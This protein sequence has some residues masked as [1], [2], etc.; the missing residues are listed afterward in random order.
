M[1][2]MTTPSLFVGA[3]TLNKSMRF[4]FDKGNFLVQGEFLF[5]LRVLNSKE[6]TN[7]QLEEIGGILFFFFYCL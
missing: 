2:F 5:S 6:S 4:R 3:I 1:S 7:W